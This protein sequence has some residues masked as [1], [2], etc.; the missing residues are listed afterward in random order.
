MGMET[1]L[2][3][4]RA[5]MAFSKMPRTLHSDVLADGAIVDRFHI[6]AGRPTQLSEQDVIDSKILFAA[7]RNAADGK[8]PVPIIN[9]AGVCLNA[10]VRIDADGAGVVEIGSRGW[11]FSHAALLT[12]DPDR[13]LAALD[14]ALLHHTLCQRDAVELRDRAARPHYSDDDFA[15]ALRFLASSP[16]AF[17][18]KLRTKLA[19]RKVGE[20]D[21]LPE[22][23][24]LWEYLTAPIKRSATLAD[25]TANEVAAERHAHILRD[26]VKAFESISLT[27]SAPDLVPKAML[28]A[29]DPGTVVRMV[30]RALRYHD[31]FALVTAFEICADWIEKDARFI[32]LGEQLLDRLVKDIAWLKNTCSLFA[33]I[34]I[35]ATA[36]LALHEVLRERPVFWRRLAAASLASLIVRTCGVREME[37]KELMAWAIRVC[38]E[39]YFLSVYDD[40]AAEPQWRPEWVDAR[41]LA[42]DAFGRLYGAFLAIPARVSPASWRERIEAAKIQADEDHLNLIMTFPAVLQGERRTPRPTLAQLG[43]DIGGA[44][45]RLET[46]PSIDNLLCLTG[47]IHSYGV[48]DGINAAVRQVVDRIRNSRV[49]IDEDVVQP[50]LILGCHIAAMTNDLELADTIADT[51]MEL[52]LQEQE[53]GL[54]QQMFFRLVEC[55]AANPDREAAQSALAG[56]F[57]ILAFRLPVSEAIVEF[58]RLLRAFRAVEPKIAML[59][60]RKIHQT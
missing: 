46:A 51:A 45:R 14:L 1:E 47:V 40:M 50:T 36:R 39:E 32:A 5:L 3:R 24:R 34:F 6:E 60:A 13:R 41:F 48:P 59:L 2:Q 25:F 19:I 57:E 22:D 53:P 49:D 18:A 10:N 35:V 54:V 12:S 9:Q 21:L 55:A 43:E 20:E 26:P 16:E 44:Y 58:F 8:P 27:F 30:E 29:L 56:R 17:S 11:R 7:F 4:M 38:G 15:Q 42:A 33:A 31:H 52:I 28:E 23:I 37:P